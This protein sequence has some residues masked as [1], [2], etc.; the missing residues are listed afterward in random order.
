T[1]SAASLTFTSSNWDSA[2]TITVT[3]VDDDI[4]D[5]SINS[6]ITLAV[7]D[8]SSDD[9]FDSLSDQTVTAANADND[10][11]SGGGG[12]GG[13]D[14]PTILIRNAG[15]AEGDAG[16][17]I[18]QLLIELSETS[19]DDVTGSYAS[20]NNTA[21]AGSD[22]TAVNGDF[23]INAGDISTSVSVS[24]LGDLIPEADET[25]TVGISS[26]VNATVTDSSGTG[27][28]FNDDAAAADPD[29]LIRNEATTEGDAG[30][31]VLNF[32]IDVLDTAT[33]DITGNFATNNGSAIAGSDYTAVNG[34]FTIIA[35]QT[36]TT[37]GVDIL[38]DTVPEVDETFT[39]DISNVSNA[40]IV[41]SSGRGTIF[42]DD[43]VGS[44]SGLDARPDNTSC[45]AP[46]RP[47]GS[48]TVNVETAFG[49][50]LTNVT[51]ILQAPGDAS[52]WYVLEQPGLIRVI[53]V[54][55]PNVAS[56]WLDFTGSVNDNFEGGMLGMAFHP[57]FP[58][59][60][61]VYVSYTAGNPMVSRL[62]RLTLDEADDPTILNE[63]ILL[64]VNQPADN[65]NGGDIAFGP[66]EPTRYLYFGLGDGGGAPGTRPQDTTQLLGSMLRIDVLGVGVGYNIPPTNP[67]SGKARCGPGANGD[68]CPEIYAWGFRNPYRWSFDD[69]VLWV[70][71]VGQDDWEEVDQVELG[72]NYGWQC[73]EGTHIVGYNVDCPAGAT[74][75]DPVI[76][77][78]HANGNQSVTGG[79]VYRG[80]AIPSLFG[81]Y[82]YGD[83]WSGRIWALESDGGGGYINEEINS[84]GLSITTFAL[85]VDGEIYL[86]DYSGSGRIRRLTANTSGN[87]TIPDD[88]DDT[89]C[90]DT[91]SLI[92]YGLQAPF[93]SDGAIKSRFIGLPNGFDIDP[94]ESGNDD[95]DFPNGTV[96]VKH[97]ELDGQLIETRLFMRHPDGVWAGYTYEWNDAETDATRVIGGKTRTVGGQQ[98]IYPGEAQCLI[99]HRDASGRSLGPETAQLNGDFTYLS[100]GRTANQLTT[101]DDIDVFDP[102]LVGAPAVQ[103]QLTNPNDTG[104]SLND[105]ARAYLHTNCSHCHRTGA[106]IPSDLDLRYTTA[107]GATNACNVA[108]SSG[109]MGIN[110][111]LL[112][113]PGEPDRSVLLNRMDRRDSNGMPPLGSNEVDDVG[114]DLIDAWITSLGGC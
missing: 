82:V 106:G 79:V 88:L 67:F 109:D 58:N 100:T 45:I 89:G 31:K 51:K 3:G 27:T 8:G 87:N 72:G 44:G 49:A 24:I 1:V 34:S 86:A 19:T 95:W 53:D 55:T 93:W 105:R 7:V 114:V 42:N 107:L 66:P 74:L 110:N 77:Y 69:T 83:F 99:C 68:D 5:G 29:I 22:Y 54:A 18:L 10:E 46:A 2:Q 13:S 20:A 41:D 97:F 104:A 91:D 38:G 57:D 15:T 11:P 94:N 26:V 81:R 47:T 56:T 35:G 64:T 90:L 14:D 92:P 76:E 16:Q 36:N 9:D 96:L 30:T 61:E 84:S 43:G 62:S 52:R 65:H 48:T 59:T 25:F 21:V 39:V 75:V 60:L 28:I 111:P 4:I 108:P 6:T 78:P 98:W 113:A 112:I 85:G 73:R 17:K 103:P 71:D 32:D 33:V 23:T 63:E 12:G 50:A 101:L 70:G 40:N 37:V 80:S 102:A